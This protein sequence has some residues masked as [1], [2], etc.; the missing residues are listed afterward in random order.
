MFT[1]FSGCYDDTMGRLLVQFKLDKKLNILICLQI[2]HSSLYRNTVNIF[3][4]S[5]DIK[6]RNLNKILRSKSSP[7]IAG[8]VEPHYQ[9]Y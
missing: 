8:P 6:M 1:K 3:K 9:D 7:A 5:L 2:K 4:S